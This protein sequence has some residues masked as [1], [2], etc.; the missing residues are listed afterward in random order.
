MT[1]QGADDQKFVHLLYQLNLTMEEMHINMV[2]VLIAVVANFILGF[3]WYTPLFGKEWDKKNGFDIS[4]K[5]G[6]GE[7]GKG[8]IIMFIGIFLMAYV[9]AHN[10]AAWGYVPGGKEMS[11]IKKIIPA[12]IFTWLGFYVPVDL[13]AVAWEKKSWKLFAINAGYHFAMLLVA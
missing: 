1:N 9:F 10:I 4:I 2:A 8:M 12:T 5:P 6:R 13:G 7:F 11:P 3:I